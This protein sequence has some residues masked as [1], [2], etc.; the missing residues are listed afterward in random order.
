VEVE[1]A[2][3]AG[4]GV[5]IWRIENAGSESR[6]GHRRSYQLE[7]HGGA[8]SLLSEEDWPQRRAAFSGQTLWT[9]ARRPGE[10]FAGGRYPNQSSGGEG[11]PAYVDGESLAA[12]DLVVWSTIGFHH[13]TRPEDW[14]VLPTVRHS[15]RLRP[16]GFFDRNPALA[17]RRD[18]AR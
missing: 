14:P 15:I 6:L 4:H 12:T 5:E 8:T 7:V 16:F 1:G 11:L 18:F 17:V 3:S 9:T 10:L 13:V 2:F